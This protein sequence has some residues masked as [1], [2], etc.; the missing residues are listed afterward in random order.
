MGFIIQRS[1]QRSPGAVQTTKIEGK[2]S[3]RIVQNANVEFREAFCP[4]TNVMG[5]YGKY[6]ED[7]EK[8]V[9]KELCNGLLN[10]LF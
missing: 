10:D 8:S 3:L 5:D 7:K 4:D 6:K 1:Q 2:I 9:P